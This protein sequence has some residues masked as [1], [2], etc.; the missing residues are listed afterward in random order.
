MRPKNKCNRCL[1]I[2]LKIFTC[3]VG[4]PKYSSISLKIFSISDIDETSEANSKKHYWF[5]D[6]FR[7]RRN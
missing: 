5:L 3:P 4:T 6:T 2:H 1:Q 7:K